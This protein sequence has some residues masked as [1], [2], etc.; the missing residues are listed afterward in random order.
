MSREFKPGSARVGWIG[1]GVMGTSMVGHLMAAGYQATVYNRSP[2]KLAPLV[3]RGAKAAGSPAEVAAASDVIFTIVGYP[4]DVRSVTL[5]AGGT[6]EGAKPGSVLVDMTTSDPALAVEIFRAAKARGVDSVDAPVSGGDVGAKEGRLSI[7]VG[8][9]P[10]WSS[11]SAPSSRSWARPSCIKG[12]PGR[13][14]TPR[15]STR[16]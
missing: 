12:P 8:G 6:L 13:A 11:R 4:A 5:D 15:W 1:T 10:G 14:S 9:E 16:S 2:A 7:M 3:E